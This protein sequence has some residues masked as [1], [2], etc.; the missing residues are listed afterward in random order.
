VYDGDVVRCGDWYYGSE[1]DAHVARLA[2][3]VRP[4]LLDCAARISS[5]LRSRR[6]DL[7]MAEQNA[8]KRET[9]HVGSA[10]NQ[11]S[12][13]GDDSARSAD[14]VRDLLYAHLDSIGRELFYAGEGP[15]LERD[16]AQYAEIFERLDKVRSL[17][18]MAGWAGG[19]D[20]PDRDSSG[21]RRVRYSPRGGSRASAAHRRDVFREIDPSGRRARADEVS[22]PSGTR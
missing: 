18:N 2:S 14:D 4:V 11:R 19:L 12:V 6:R 17:L 3:E 7:T 10:N 9:R 15:V 13:D 21:P 5:D 20:A 8:Q 22:R 1:R 16:P